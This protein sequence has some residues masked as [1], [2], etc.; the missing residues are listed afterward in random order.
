EGAPF[1]R[2]LA[3]VSGDPTVDGADGNKRPRVL[4]I[5]GE[6]CVHPRGAMVEQGSR[7][8]RLS[9]GYEEVLRLIEAVGHMAEA[10][11]AT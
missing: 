8:L 1:F 9:Y 3:R 11:R 10:A 7:G 4:Y 2:R 6:F 5:P